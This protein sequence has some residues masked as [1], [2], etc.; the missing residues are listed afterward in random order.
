MVSKKLAANA[1]HAAKF[2]AALAS[3][4]RLLIMCHLADSGE[5]SVGAICEKLMISQSSLSQH[6]AKL[7]RLGVVETRRDSQ[8]IYYSC[9]SEA[10]RDL[11]S[12]MDNLYGAGAPEKRAHLFTEKQQ[13]N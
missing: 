13:S 2:L 11:L 1:E 8:T 3:Q 10:V 5:M 4:H 6:L 12:V 9:N 7:R